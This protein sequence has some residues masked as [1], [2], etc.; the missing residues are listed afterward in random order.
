MKRTGAPR[1]G[2]FPRLSGLMFDVDG[3]LLLSDRSLDGYEL[4][5]GAIETLATLGARGVPYGPDDGTIAPVSALG[6]L[7]FA[8]EPALAAVRHVLELY[9]EW[10]ESFRLPSGFNRIAPGADPRGWISEGY[11]GLD[12]GLAVLMIENY[13]SGLIWKLMR[14]CPPIRTGLERAGF[15]GGWL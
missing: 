5:P 7:P 4:L 13:R 14:D 2:R 15:E 8:P 12:Q 9:P 1:A 11:F 3:T 6:S 10:T